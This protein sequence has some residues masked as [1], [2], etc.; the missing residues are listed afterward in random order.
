MNTLQIF[1]GFLWAP[2]IGWSVGITFVWL[3]IYFSSEGCLSYA[4]PKLFTELGIFTKDEQKRLLHVAMQ[5]AGRWRSFI[6]FVVVLAFA[7]FGAALG[8]TIPKI[9]ALPDSLWVHALFAGVFGGIGGWLAVWLG[10]LF[11]RPFL[12]RGI[13]RARLEG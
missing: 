12:K 10:A 11:I 5:E 9:P 4:G 13:E 8:R 7:P 6:P 3:A 2:L 1:F